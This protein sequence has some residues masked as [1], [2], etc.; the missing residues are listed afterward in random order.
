MNARAGLTPR[1]IDPI[2]A[3]AHLVIGGAFLLLVTLPPTIAT[4]QE[5]NARIKAQNYLPRCL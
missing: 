4:S 1:K 5:A 2:L 3:A